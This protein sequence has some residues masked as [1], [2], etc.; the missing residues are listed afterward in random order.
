MRKDLDN[1]LCQRYPLIF[2]D[3][4]RSIKE[5]CM[6][7][8]FSCGD[9]WFDL[10]DSLCERLQFW[11]DHNHAPQIVAALF[12]ARGAWAGSLRERI[13]RPQTSWP[14]LM[15]SAHSNKTP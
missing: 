13:G 6:G 4:S 1:L 3:R 10:I 7:W 11:T 15:S 12:I 9:G 2:A 8:G 5:S 14:S